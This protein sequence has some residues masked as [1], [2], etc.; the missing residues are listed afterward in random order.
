MPFMVRTELIT[1]GKYEYRNLTSITETRASYSMG[2]PEANAKA[3]RTSAPAATTIIGIKIAHKK[4]MAVSLYR[5]LISLQD[6]VNKR[7][8]YWMSS[9]AAW[10]IVWAAYSGRLSNSQSVVSGVTILR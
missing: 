7:C 10:I 6:K 1:N 5:I 2:L 4:P 3:L 9:F 8:L